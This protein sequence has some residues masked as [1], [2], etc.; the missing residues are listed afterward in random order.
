M[1]TTI[2]VGDTLIYQAMQDTGEPTE[3]AVV[4]AGLQLL[5]QMRAHRNRDFD[6]FEQH[7]GL[8]VIHPSAH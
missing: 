5:I 2:E 1:S 8:K 7:L 4:E 3:R 6:P